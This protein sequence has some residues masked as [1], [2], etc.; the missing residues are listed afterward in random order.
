MSCSRRRK[1]TLTRDTV[2]WE[3]TYLPLHRPQSR[4][5]EPRP[6]VHLVVLPGSPGIADLVVCVI[7]FDEILEDGAGLEEADG[8]AVGEGVGDRGDA[9]VRV[10]GEEPGFFLDWG[11]LE[12]RGKTRTTNGD[13]GVQDVCE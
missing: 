4:V 1:E 10:D 6:V 7:L 2:G 8:L 9:P 3:T 13:E 5:L 12:I 11:V